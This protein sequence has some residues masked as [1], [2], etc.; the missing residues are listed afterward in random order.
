[1][2][3]WHEDCLA[4]SSIINAIILVCTDVRTW[5]A[6]GPHPAASPQD[7]PQRPAWAWR[8]AP[9]TGT[10]QQ[11]PDE[12]Q[13]MAYACHLGLHAGG[14]PEPG[15]GRR[16][17][18]AHQGRLHDHW[19]EAPAVPPRHAPSRGAGG[20][21]REALDR[22]AR[23]GGKTRAV[24]PCAQQQRWGSLPRRGRVAIRPRGPC[25]SSPAR[26]PSRRYAPRGPLPRGPGH[27]SPRV[28]SA[29]HRQGSRANAGDRPCHSATAMVAAPSSDALLPM[30]AEV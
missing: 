4:S 29:V 10:A 15:D 22:D 18:R 21:A 17:T 6:D 27:A 9:R 8:L 14:G 3:A 23:Q 13:S 20:S 30:S 7:P 25:G 19:R 12:G 26:A 11:G 16:V 5:H 1:M 28:A 24:A 2:C